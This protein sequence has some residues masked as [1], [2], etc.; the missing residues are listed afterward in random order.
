MPDERYEGKDFKKLQKQQSNLRLEAAFWQAWIALNGERVLSFPDPYCTFTSGQ[1]DFEGYRF[2]FAWGYPYLV[3]VEIEG[4]IWGKK[5][6]EGEILAGGGHTRGQGY[7][8]DC[9]K[10]N[11]AAQ[12]GWIV[13]RLAGSMI[14][15]DLPD[16]IEQLFDVLMQQKKKA[17]ALR[18]LSRMTTERDQLLAES[19]RRRSLLDFYDRCLRGIE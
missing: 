11:A 9:R 16:H 4:G 8:K 18:I 14:T 12:R 15:H 10:Y 17:N 5:N 3:A 7:E 19:P 13:I 6:E 2:D 1:F